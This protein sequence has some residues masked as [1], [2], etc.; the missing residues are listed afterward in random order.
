MKFKEFVTAT[1]QHWVDYLTRVDVLRQQGGLHTAG[2]TN[3]FPSLL[4]CTRSPRHFVAE[5]VGAQEEFQGLSVKK[6]RMASAEEYFGQFPAGRSDPALRLT[7]ARNG[8]INLTLS[9]DV[10]FEQ[11]RDR[12]PFVT[13]YPTRLNRTGGHGSPIVFGSGFQSCMFDNCMILNHLGAVFRAKHILN[14]V[15]VSQGVAKRELE[16]WLEDVRRGNRVSGVHTCEP[17]AGVAL[18]T[19]GQFSALYLSSS[20]RET[21]IGEFL[22]DHPRVLELAAG[23]LQFVYEPYL[24]WI[25]GPERNEDDAINPDMLVQRPDHD[26]DIYDLKTALLDRTTVTK[27]GR[28]RRRFVDKVEEGVAQLANYR[29]Y[30]T[31]PANQ[32][33]AVEKYDAQVTDPRL[34][35]VVGSLENVREQ[36]VREASRR[37]KD[38]TLIDFDTLMQLFLMAATRSGRA[39]GTESGIS[40]A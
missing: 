37:L 32:A 15:V 9:H 33:R 34:V 39:G 14:A 11:V 3:L 1:E 24:E 5:L 10:A 35:L 29:E 31:Y 8:F 6:Q 21:T 27:G 26:W 18:S 30:F 19:A 13:L 22:R 40:G 36:E 7:S 20:V 4:L 17:G 23:S 12:F 28:R 16:E 38:I 25:E 2:G